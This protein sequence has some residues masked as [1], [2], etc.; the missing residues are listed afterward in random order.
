ML[1]CQN[2]SP[3]VLPPSLGGEGGG[4]SSQ[5]GRPVGG[6]MTNHKTMSEEHHKVGGE[7][8]TEC[9]LPE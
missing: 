4:G 6:L 8:K 3:P 9:L 2:V 1:P 7:I 5:G